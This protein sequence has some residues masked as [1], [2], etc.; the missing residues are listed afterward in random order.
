MGAENHTNEDS[1]MQKSRFIHSQL[2]PLIKRCQELSVL[3][4]RE[5]GKR[6]T[7]WQSKKLLL[8]LPFRQ[9]SP[10]T[11]NFNFSMSPIRFQM[12][13]PGG[14]STTTNTQESS[15]GESSDGS[16]DE[17]EE[18]MVKIDILELQNREDKK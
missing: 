1:L 10:K 13:F 12:L 8:D 2:F 11:N 14:P 5:D 16:D 6:M 4:S 7:K 18:G 9:P 17:G 15:D 3:Y